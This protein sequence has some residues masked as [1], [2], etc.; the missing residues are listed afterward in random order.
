MSKIIISYIKSSFF[1]D[2]LS[3]LLQ[4]FL[5]S[6]QFF[7]GHFLSKKCY[8]W[9]LMFEDRFL[10]IRELIHH[11]FS[12]LFDFLLSIG[13]SCFSIIWS[14]ALGTCRLIIIQSIAHWGFPFLVLYFYQ[15]SVFLYKKITYFCVTVTSCEV[16]SCVSEFVLMINLNILLRAYQIDNFKITRFDSSE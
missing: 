2:K 1:I 4:S 8:F 11:F 5:F 10:I 13:I 16:K 7:S 12:E 3:K 14:Y 6:F 9:R 15:S